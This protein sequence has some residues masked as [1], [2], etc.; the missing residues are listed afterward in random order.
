LQFGIIVVLSPHLRPLSFYSRDNSH[1]LLS[2]DHAPPL[3]YIILLAC[4]FVM[5]KR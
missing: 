2:H 3:I 5:K 1:L 4:E